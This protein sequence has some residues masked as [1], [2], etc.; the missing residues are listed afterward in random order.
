M[1]RIH[2]FKKLILIDMNKFK[3]HMQLRYKS[4]FNAIQFMY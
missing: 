4:V 1:Y 2:S 3:L